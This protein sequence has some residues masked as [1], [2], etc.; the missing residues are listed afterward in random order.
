M[1]NSILYTSLCLLLCVSSIAQSNDADE[2]KGKFKRENTFLGAAVNL[3]LG[4]RF[5][6]VGVNPE[7]G[8]SFNNWLDAG[9]ALNVN[10]FSQNASDFSS[11]RF[12]NFNYGAGT[13]LRIWPVNFL[14][15]QVQPEYNWINSSQKNVIS[16][17]TFK[18]NYSSESLL[19]GIGYGSRMIGSQYSYVTLMIDVL[20]NI[21]S[22]YRDQF[23]DPLPVFR[24]GFGMYLNRKK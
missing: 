19:V 21:N 5:F 16:G 1:K 9:V 18:Y 8:Y 12:R 10:Y 24:A 13:F 4:N 15:L 17:Q 22:P 7:V 2:K 3:S 20:Q 23:N 11:T 14:H 6:N